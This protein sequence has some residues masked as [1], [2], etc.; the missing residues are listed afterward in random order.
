MTT[1]DGMIGEITDAQHKHLKWKSHLMDAIAHGQSDI[2]PDVAGRQFSQCVTP[3]VAA[4]ADARDLLS[5]SAWMSSSAC[6]TSAGAGRRP[7]PECQAARC[8]DFG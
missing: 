4:E 8:S 2:T 3:K 5:A 1:K 7:G 6:P